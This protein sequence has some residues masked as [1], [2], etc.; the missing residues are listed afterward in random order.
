[1]TVAIKKFRVQKRDWDHRKHAQLPRLPAA[2]GIFLEVCCHAMKAQPPATF[3][4]DLHF[5]LSASSGFC[6]FVASADGLPAF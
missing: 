1:M 4:I 5:P 3:T 6:C 2:L